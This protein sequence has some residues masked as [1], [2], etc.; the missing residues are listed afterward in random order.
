MMKDIFNNF[1]IFL[2]FR[3]GEPLYGIVLLSEFKASL[4]I[5]DSLFMI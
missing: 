2:F 1:G 3:I 5:I 4:Y